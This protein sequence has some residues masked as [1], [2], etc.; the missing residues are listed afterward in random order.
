MRIVDSERPDRGGRD[1]TARWRF[2]RHR[3]SFEQ[4]EQLGLRLEP[5]RLPR[6]FIVIDRV[7]R[8]GGELRE[9]A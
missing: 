7:E 5:I 6:E 9:A 1:S 8:P 3:P 4:L 2:P